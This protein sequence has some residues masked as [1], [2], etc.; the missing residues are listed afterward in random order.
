MRRRNIIIGVVGLLVVIGVIGAIYGTKGAPEN[1]GQVIFGTAVDSSAMKVTT[2]VTS[3]KAGTQVGWVAYLN[4][5]VKG[6]SVTLTL[7]RVDSGGAE[8]T[9]ASKPFDVADPNFNELEFNPDNSIASY[10]PGTYKVRYVRPSDGTV[11]ATGTIT[12]TP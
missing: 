5:A 6:T 3:I 7:A 8:Q 10:G 11:L 9:V 2:P 4:D 12:V 1:A